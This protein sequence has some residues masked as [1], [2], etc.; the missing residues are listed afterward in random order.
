MNGTNLINA[1]APPVPAP[2]FLPLAPGAGG[3]M[4]T[5]S[6]VPGVSYQLQY[7]ADLTE[8][9]WINLGSATT[10]SNSITSATDAFT[11]SQR[12]YR[13]MVVP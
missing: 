11:N 13:V 3:I 4:L 2:L 9:N 7:N 6:T 5:W 1:L 8:T 12:F 10:A